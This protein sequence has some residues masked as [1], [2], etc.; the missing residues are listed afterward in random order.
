M[1]CPE[2]IRAEKGDPHCEQSLTTHDGDGLIPFSWLIANI[3]FSTSWFKHRMTDKLDALIASQGHSL[4]HAIE[5]LTDIGNDVINV[6]NANR[7]PDKIRADA[8]GCEFIL[9][10]LSVCGGGRMTGQ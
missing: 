2:S 6:L 9:I 5:R 3:L 7:Y 1:N 4:R 10:Q 8:G